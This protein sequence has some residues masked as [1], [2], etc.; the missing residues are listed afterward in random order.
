MGFRVA[1][2]AAGKRLELQPPV[3]RPLNDVCEI[4]KMISES[5][6]KT[7]RHRVFKAPDWAI[8]TIELSSRAECV[9][10][11]W[12]VSRR[13]REIHINARKARLETF[14]RPDL[15]RVFG[16][17][18]SEIS[19]VAFRATSEIDPNAENLE[20]SLVPGGN[21]QRFFFP[22]KTQRQFPLPSLARQQRVNAIDNDNKFL[23]QGYTAYRHMA[24]IFHRPREV[25][26][27]LD[28]GCGC[29]GVGRHF[30]KDTRFDYFGCDIDPDNIQ[31]CADNLGADRFFH[32]PLEAPKALVV[33]QP[34]DA[35]FGISVTSHLAP[36]KIKEWGR[37]L[38]L[39]LK[40]DGLLAVTT[41][42]LQAATKESDW[43]LDQL[44]RNGIVFGPDD[45]EIGRIIGNP[46][47]YGISFQS[48][49]GL[50]ALLP[51][52]DLLHHGTGEWG[53]QDLLIF[54]RSPR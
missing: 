36:E 13:E 2:V 47:Y 42:G 17:L 49:A 53:H 3:P 40:S 41:L 16:W 23:T 11:G 18:R 10:S 19:I 14:I 26:K 43:F 8:D 30:L 48:P 33:D 7:L 50:V 39:N 52:F 5:S 25:V 6:A 21:I 22:L 37:W 46:E 45:H 44:L 34:M 51:E 35:I 54:R 24:H 4:V 12:Y 32:L 27:I 31:W 38:A 1:D 20:F 28:W 15:E 9:I 29:G